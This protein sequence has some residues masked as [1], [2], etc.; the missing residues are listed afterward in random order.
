LRTNPRNARTH[1]DKQIAQVAASINKFGFT[2]PI[3]I[4][5]HGVLIAGP[6]SSGCGEASEL[7]DLTDHHGKRAF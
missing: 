3:L 2:N 5:E 6:C 4:D 7:P 1:D